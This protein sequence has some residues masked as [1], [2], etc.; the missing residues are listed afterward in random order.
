MI[1]RFQAPY[2]FLVFLLLINASSC[3]SLT[4]M[5]RGTYSENLGKHRK[6]FK[7]TNQEITENVQNYQEQAHRGSLEAVTEQLDELL[8]H[9]KI[10]HKRIK[11]ITGYTIQIYAGG[12]KE[13]AFK[14]R[15]KLHMYFPSFQA[16]IKYNLPNY[17]VR[18]G[19]F[20][21]KLE[22]NSVYAMIKKYIPQAI[23]RPIS[24]ASSTMLRRKTTD[25]DA[26]E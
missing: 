2:R 3:T 23:V 13:A 17:T 6:T 21:D 8:A 24:F 20:L 14:A 19:R 26:E 11:H 4:Q 9:K 7:A 18:V 12:S 15:N 10:A 1:D 5:Q 16:E 25:K 22:V